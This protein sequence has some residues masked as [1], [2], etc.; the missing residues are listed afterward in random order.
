MYCYYRQT[1]R[2]VSSIRIKKIIQYSIYYTILQE[3]DNNNKY[4]I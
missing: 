1:R 2:V 4:L 3:Q